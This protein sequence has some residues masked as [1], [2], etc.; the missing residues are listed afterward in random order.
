MKF[1]IIVYG[2]VKKDSNGLERIVDVRLA[3]WSALAIV[4]NFNKSQA[5]KDNGWEFRVVT[6]TCIGE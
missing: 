3:E 6:L 1:D 2:I 4:D 5:S